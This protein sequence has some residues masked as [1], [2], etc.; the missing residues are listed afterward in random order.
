[1][2]L[3]V[4]ARYMGS[5][6]RPAPWTVLSQSVGLGPWMSLSRFMVPSVGL[7]NSQLVMGPSEGLDTELTLSRPVGFSVGLG[8][9]MTLGL[10]GPQ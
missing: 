2:C 9:W 10:W 7:D 6:V 4:L 3:G 5:P 1:M 8:P